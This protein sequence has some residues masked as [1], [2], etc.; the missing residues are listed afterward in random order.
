LKASLLIIIIYREKGKTFVFYVPKK[1]IGLSRA[2]LI[3]MDIPSN[4]PGIVVDFLGTDRGSITL[5]IH[6]SFLVQE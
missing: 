5:F 1:I 2:L 6:V 3:S 4:L